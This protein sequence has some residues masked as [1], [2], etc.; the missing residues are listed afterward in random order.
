MLSGCVMCGACCVAAGATRS[1]GPACGDATV[2]PDMS[3]SSPALCVPEWSDP[4]KGPL[5]LAP[6][7]N[8]DGKAFGSFGVVLALVTWAFVLVTISLACAVFSPVWEAWRRS[9]A[10]GSA[11]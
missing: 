9:E 3:V 11:S 2:E 8:A 7:V 10:A 6:T 1:R 5:F 4:L